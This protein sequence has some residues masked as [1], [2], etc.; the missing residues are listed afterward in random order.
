[1]SPPVLRDGTLAYV[2]LGSNLGD[3][4]QYLRSAVELMEGEG[5]RVVKTS[6]VYETDPVGPAQPLFLNAAAQVTTDLS[7]AALLD[8]LKSIEQCTGRSAGE[9]W[10]PREIDVDLLLYG[11]ELTESPGLTL[12]H[13]ELTRRA[14][15][16][17]PLLEI[18][19]DLELPSGEPLSAFCEPNP[20]GVRL[21][22]Q[23]GSIFG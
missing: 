20:D 8:A 3:R 7:P 2:G 14:F 23:P 1:M 15:V 19:P 18:D 22:R 9:R 21:Y 11:D 6:S 4:E 10:G 5:I 17:V 13:P 16:M 12:P